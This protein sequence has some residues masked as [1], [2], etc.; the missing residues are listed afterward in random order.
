VSKT[1]IFNRLYYIDATFDPK[2]KAL[3]LKLQ[4]VEGRLLNT[5]ER[6]ILI[7]AVDSIATDAVERPSNDP[8]QSLHFKTAARNIT[9]AALFIR[10]VVHNA[11]GRLLDSNIN[12]GFD[13]RESSLVRLVTD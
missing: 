11:S 13:P 12:L 4:T 3:E 1:T 6:L 10:K 9:E 8:K 7:N 2:T 5:T